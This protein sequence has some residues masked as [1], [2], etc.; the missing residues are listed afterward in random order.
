MPQGKIISLK[1][2][3]E[4]AST[5][6]AAETNE[7]DMLALA[8]A[9]Y[10][11]ALLEM[12][13]CSLDACPAL[14]SELKDS[15]GRLKT[16]LSATMSRADLAATDASVQENLRGWGRSTARHY[17][18]TAG[19]VK[20]LLLVMART[21]ESAGA[22]DQRCAKQIGEVTARLEEIATL[23]D[24]TQIRASVESS[25][26]CLKTSI[27]RM[28]AEGKAAFDQLHERLTTYQTKLQEAEALAFR[29]ALTGVRSRL[30]VES[31]IES[32]IAAGAVFCVAI[33]DIDGFKKVN[34]RHGHLIGDELLKQFATELR[35][36]CRQSDVIGRW[37]GD[38]F[39]IVLDRSKAEAG[40]QI[41]RLSKWVCG[42]Y[43][44]QAKPNPLKL[45]VDASIGLAEHLPEEAINDLLARA[46]A[47]M[48]ERKAVARAIRRESAHL[49]STA[50]PEL[51]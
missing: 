49:A 43:T 14:G 26:A 33:V 19:E 30:C 37:G 23:E 48:Y 35:S 41:D 31:M 34:D 25:A 20:E 13:S 47:A 38:E 8:M 16:T 42:D 28:T 29:D 24:L 17:Q 21:A 51:L 22:R 11:S 46:D 12:G 4:S 9:A 5:G 44:V 1:E 10:G 39:I 7:T 3:L 2:Y 15:L 27:E 32:R 18:Q 50:I 45:K 36:V 6:A 40:A